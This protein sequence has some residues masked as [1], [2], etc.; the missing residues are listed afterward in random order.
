MDQMLDELNTFQSIGE[1]AMTVIEKLAVKT[2]LKK[3]AKEI[4]WNGQQIV[5]NGIYADIPIERYHND[6]SLFDGFSISSSGLRQVLRRPSEYWCYSPY[7]PNRYPREESKALNFGQAAHML[8]LGEEGF[9]SQF[10]LKPA[11]LNGKPWQ[12]NRTECRQWLKDCQQAGRTVIT[13][14]EIEHIKRIANNLDRHPMVKQGVLN[15]HIERSIIYKDENIWLKSRPDI[16]ANNSGDF[17]DLKTA[18]DVSKDALEKT[19]YNHGYHVQAAL[20]RMA[21]REVVGEDAF[22]SFTFVFVEKTPPYDVCIRQLRPQD[23]DLGEQQAR[24][25]IKIVK[26]CLKTNEWPG[27]DGIAPSVDWIELPEWARSEIENNL[28]NNDERVAA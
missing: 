16:F 22:S 26:E 4:Q 10:A 9:S 23:I 7:N 28:S 3:T 21:I 5:A 8:I 12:G 14:A 1:I 2:S 17:F 27:L 13:D 15:G 11:E 20:V 6:T 25:A 24:Y 19:I 18:N